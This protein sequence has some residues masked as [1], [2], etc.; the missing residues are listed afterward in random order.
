MPRIEVNSHWSVSRFRS[1]HSTVLSVIRK[2]H[3]ENLTF[4]S[5]CRDLSVHLQ[6][7]CSTHLQSFLHLLTCHRI[8]TTL[9]SR[10][11]R[12]HTI[13]I[14]FRTIRVR[15]RFR[16]HLVSSSTSSLTTMYCFATIWTLRVR[17]DTYSISICFIVLISTRHWIARITIYEFSFKRTSYNLSRIISNN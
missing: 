2:P 11:L 4:K 5:S 8:S 17:I 10:I 9:I 1:D 6:M 16:M 7:Q 13:R 15:F 3:T 12:I 14:R